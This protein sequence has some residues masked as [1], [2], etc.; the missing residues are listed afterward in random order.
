MGEKEWEGGSG[1][2]GEGE[3]SGRRERREDRGKQAD[4][5]TSFPAPS[6]DTLHTTL[7]GHSTCCRFLTLSVEVVH[8]TLGGHFTWRYAELGLFRT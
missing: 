4:F 7:Y 3:K 2:E 8:A 1:R 5:G 6:T